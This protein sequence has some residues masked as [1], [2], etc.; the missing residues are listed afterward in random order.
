MQESS[1]L[2]RHASMKLSVRQRDR[3]N[4]NTQVIGMLYYY[5]KFHPFN[6]DPHQITP[7]PALQQEVVFLNL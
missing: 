2:L 3:G 4:Y 1:S 6:V 5:L 7:P